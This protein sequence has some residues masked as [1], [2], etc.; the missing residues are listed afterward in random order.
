MAV[1]K[2]GN[3]IDDEEDFVEQ[4]DEGLFEQEGENYEEEASAPSADKPKK[5]V[6]FQVEDEEDLLYGES[7]SS[8]K[9]NNVSF[10]RV[11]FIG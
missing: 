11:I 1:D 9:M 10:F 8:F 2:F 6:S 7:G 4:Q 3:T 5:T